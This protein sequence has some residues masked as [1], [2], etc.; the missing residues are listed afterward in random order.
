MFEFRNDQMEA[1]EDARLP[2][3]ENY[4]VQHLSEFAARHCEIIGEPGV[5]KV[6]K[7]GVQNSAKYGMNLRRSARLHIELMF[8]L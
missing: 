1:F 4:M 6:I 5:R 8:F 3:F 2:A 7:L